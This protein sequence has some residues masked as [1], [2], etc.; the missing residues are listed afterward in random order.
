MKTFLLKQCFFF[1]PV[2]I[3]IQACISEPRKT[4]SDWAMEGGEVTRARLIEPEARPLYYQ[5]ERAFNA[6]NYDQAEKLLLQVKSRY[7]H[8]KADAYA[9]YRMGIIQYYYENYVRASKYFEYFLKQAPQAQFAFDATYNWAAS[10]FQLS[11]YERAYQILTQLKQSELQ[12]QG[13]RRSEV[14]YQ[15]TAR[16]AAALNNHAGVIVASAFVMQLPIEDSLRDQI[17]SSINDR[18]SKINDVPTLEKLLKEVEEVTTKTKIE[19]KL[20][21]LNANAAANTA[22]LGDSATPDSS[23]QSSGGRISDSSPRI[24][25]LLP[26]TGRGASYGKK[27]LDAILLAAKVFFPNTDSDFHIYIEDTASSPL[28][29]QSGLDTLVKER[30]VVAVIGPLN[31]KEAASVADRAQKIGIPNISLSSKEGLSLGG[32]YIFQNALTPTVQLESLVRYCI[33][34]KHLKRFAILSPRNTFGSEMSRA[35]W[36]AVEKYG[37]KIADYRTYPPN[38]TDFRDSVKE[39]VGL[40]SLKYRSFESLRLDEYIKDQKQKTGK[41]PK[42]QF[43]PVIDFDALFI[44]DSPKTVAQIAPSLAYFDV[45]DLTLLGTTEWNS[46]QFYSRGGKYVEGA[47]FPGGLNLGT[48]NSSAQ[49]FIRIYRDAYGSYPDMLAAQSFEAMRLIAT[50]LKNGGVSNRSDLAGALSLLRDVESPL[51]KLSFNP[52]RLA[53][54]QLPILTLESGGIITEH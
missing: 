42:V 39:L 18:L 26:L 38:E 52:D 5:A 37:G 28:I 24:G 41:E 49:E 6:K 33:L 21:L 3:I 54:R 45:S 2:A 32:S 47:I 51:G 10:E 35:F 36:G 50:V 12:S 1:I 19:A 14:V 16:T 48:R 22:A 23:F 8:S 25:V 31:W 13:A 29:A 46:N 44:P 7:P 17:A 40:S 4:S 27:A 43:P 34:Q 11:H 9:T 20:Q 15:L 53:L 30:D